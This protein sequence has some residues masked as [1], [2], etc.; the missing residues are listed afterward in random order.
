MP[1]TLGATGHWLQPK[2]LDMTQF[3]PAESSWGTTYPVPDMAPPLLTV[4]VGPPT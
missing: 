3:H 1:C 2:K 4:E